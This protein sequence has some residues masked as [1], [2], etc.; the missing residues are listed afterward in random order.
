MRMDAI[1]LKHLKHFV[2]LAEALN[3]SRAAI[4]CHVSQPT[5][6]VSIQQLEAHLNLQLVVRTSR[7][8]ELTEAGREFYTHAVQLTRRASQAFLDIQNFNKGLTRTLSVGFHASM[9]FRGLPEAIRRFKE[10]AGDVRV[11]LHELSSK[12][13]FDAVLA[14]DLDLGFTHSLASVDS[15][16]VG[17]V[18]LFTERFLLCVPDYYQFPEEDVS[19]EKLQDENFIIFDRNAS[20]YYFDT[21]TSICIQAG[22]SPRIEHHS[23]Q[24]LTTVALV[25]K[26]LGVAIVPECLAQTGLKGVKF[27][28]VKTDVV[29]HLQCIYALSRKAEH[30]NAFI[31]IART[32]LQPSGMPMDRTTAACGSR[33]NSSMASETGGSHQ[34]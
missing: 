22:F 31:E 2:A 13:Q 17:C 30:V 7:N 10:E 5:F 20:P 6:S 29:S 26:G 24:W 19:L 12:A 25:S 4:R 3:F 16:A 21:I 28:R 27:L 8:V 15:K 14:G 34:E 18:N 23:K 11:S 32:T 1:E 9:I 33:G